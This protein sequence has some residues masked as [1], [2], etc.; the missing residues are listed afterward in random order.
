VLASFGHWGWTLPVCLIKTSQRDGYRK[1][2]TSS[3]Y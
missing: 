2:E 1:T 3:L